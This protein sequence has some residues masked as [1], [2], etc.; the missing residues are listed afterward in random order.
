MNLNEEQLKRLAG[1][2]TGNMRLEQK[3]SGDDL[4][5]SLPLNASGKLS[6]SRKIVSLILLTSR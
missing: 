6:E 3:S 4:G 5:V 2:V 1:I